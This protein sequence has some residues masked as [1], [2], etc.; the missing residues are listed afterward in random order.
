MPGFGTCYYVINTYDMS[1]CIN[2]IN[3]FMENKNK[4]NGNLWFVFTSIISFD[5]QTP[6]EGGYLFNKPLLSTHC[7]QDA[8]LRPGVSEVK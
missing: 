5:L 2:F 1:V 8:M 3:I 7:V 4:C 6:L